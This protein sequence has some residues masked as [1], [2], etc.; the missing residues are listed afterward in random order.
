MWF[1]Q[2]SETDIF[3]RSLSWVEYYAICGKCETIDDDENKIEPSISRD[4]QFWKFEK[5]IYDWQ[6]FQ[7][8]K[9]PGQIGAL[10]GRNVFS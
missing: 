2:I 8:W 1:K 4:G 5:H 10:V 7:E 3:P 6:D 9:M